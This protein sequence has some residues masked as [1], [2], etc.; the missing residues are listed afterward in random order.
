MIPS[1]TAV[2]ESRFIKKL[3]RDLVASF[4]STLAEALGASLLL[5]VVGASDL[6][7]ESQLEASRN[8]LREIGAEIVPSRLLLNRNRSRERG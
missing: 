1:T 5:F 3:P 8:V 7:Y 2:P 4:R 6:T